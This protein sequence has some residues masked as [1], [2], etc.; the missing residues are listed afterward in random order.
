MRKTKLMEKVL[1]LNGSLQ[2][3]NLPKNKKFE[4]F[5]E[6]YKPIFGCNSFT[7]TY[8]NQE[9]DL[10]CQLYDI[11]HPNSK[12]RTS[13]YKG[14]QLA[15]IDNVK[16][17]EGIIEE[18]KIDIPSIVRLDDVEKPQLSDNYLIVPG[19]IPIEDIIDQ[20]MLA[21]LEYF[22]NDPENKFLEYLYDRID[23]FV[24][25]YNNP[26]ETNKKRKQRTIDTLLAKI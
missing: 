23:K 20:T 15:F 24:G 19:K 3:L 6:N 17:Y 18:L 4:S 14:A 5:N 25:G 7:K 1:Y 2:K 9:R 10:T 13:L 22:C 11:Y 16:N 12:L 26:I 21:Q 8:S